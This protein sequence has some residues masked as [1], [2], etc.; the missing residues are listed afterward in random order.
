[1]ETA[2]I[3]T[4]ADSDI[5][6]LSQTSGKH[7]TKPE[8]RRA[9]THLVKRVLLGDIGLLVADYLSVKDKLTLYSA[10][11]NYYES[12]NHRYAIEGSMF[13]LMHTNCIP[14]E[15]Q[16]LKDDVRDLQIT[17]SQ[18]EM[19]YQ[20]P[21]DKLKK[22][23]IQADQDLNQV[24]VELKKCFRSMQS[25]SFL[26]IFWL[27]DTDGY[28]CLSGFRNLEILSISSAGS[29]SDVAFLSNLK[30]LKH[31]KLC[32]FKQV[33]LKPLKNLTQL[34][35]L[36]LYSDLIGDLSVLIELK[37]LLGLYINCHN[38]SDVSPIFSLTGLKTLTI[39]NCMPG[40]NF[41]RL[42]GLCNLENLAITDTVLGDVSF[43]LKLPRLINLSVRY[44][45]LRETSTLSKLFRLKVLD[46]ADT[47]L[48]DVSFLEPLRNLKSLYLS[49]NGPC[50][51]SV[52]AQVSNLEDLDLAFSRTS[53]IS[54]LESLKKLKD[55]NLEGNYITDF[56]PLFR[57][58]SLRNLVLSDEEEGKGVKESM[59]N[60][61][62]L[63]GN[64]LE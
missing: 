57:L 47:H 39:T 30:N 21:M 59:P 62:I 46:L 24:S 4:L 38:L 36:V 49:N 48:S 1:M 61:R 53:D 28:K 11:K 26:E 2:P 10:S 44:S 42:V 13:D 31:L 64:Y 3:D 6:R 7:S 29:Q 8:G 52:L 34:K 45:K 56:S 17:I 9:S 37:S 16:A 14:K 20:F 32:N 50:D 54:I 5:S 40:T 19:L 25:L 35:K 23:S 15:V 55:L 51:L 58:H 18:V 41:N 43:L 63:F 27:K 12:F 33:D 60:V 22:F